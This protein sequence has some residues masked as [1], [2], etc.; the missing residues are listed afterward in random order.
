MHLLL[1][2]EQPLTLI[3]TRLSLHSNAYMNKGLYACQKS[4]LPELINLEVQALGIKTL[5]I[6][7]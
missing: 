5:G 2:L 7:V 4:S 1:C 6:A 3:Y